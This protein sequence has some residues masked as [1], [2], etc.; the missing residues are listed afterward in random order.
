EGLPERAKCSFEFWSKNRVYHK[1]S[2]IIRVQAG[3]DTPA[4][5]CSLRINA[6]S[7]KTK[8][9]R[10]TTF[11]IIVLPAPQPLPKRTIEHNPPIPLID[12]WEKQM[13]SFGEKHA[14]PKTIAKKGLWEGNV[15]YYDGER[16]Y[17]QIADY[18]GDPSW[19]AAASSIENVYRDGYVLKHK[20]RIPGWRIFSHGLL[21]DYRHTKDEESKRAALLLANNAAYTRRGGGVLAAL[22]RETAY[23]LNAYLIAQEFGAPV[24]D[25]YEHAVDYAL[26]HMDQWFV[27]KSFL[28]NYSNGSMPPFMVGLTSE[29][30]IHHYHRTKDPRIPHTIKTAMDWL[31]E[32]AWIESSQSFY[33]RNSDPYNPKSK[34]E[35]GAPDLN[36]LI[37][38]AF[39]WL[40]RLTGDAIYQKR[41]DQIFEG[42]VKGAWLDGG[43]QF[44]QVYRWSFDYV[45]WRRDIAVPGDRTPPVMSDLTVERNKEGTVIVK[46][47]TDEPATMQLQF[48]NTPDCKRQLPPSRYLVTSF[49]QHVPN[50][51]ADEK[52]YIRVLAKDA[53]GNTSK[54]EVTTF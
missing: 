19:L 44:S 17:Y 33:Y 38:P 43:K 4:G 36:L 51:L 46:W 35:K 32:N 23:S 29:A 21:E 15:W 6:V 26:G 40:Y 12:R 16:V 34:P 22:S 54:S 41:G 20:G 1:G 13:V 5:V 53:S 52:H 48:G 42:G 45:Q 11:Q 8:V 39:A 47:K 18:T 3:K 9:K 50:L 28:R 30:L 24:H 25:K 37:A 14:D 2:G 49:Q 7:E 10:D 27:S 31:W